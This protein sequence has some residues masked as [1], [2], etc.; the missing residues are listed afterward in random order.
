MKKKKKTK[1]YG[2][3][4]IKFRT[5]LLWANLPKEYKLF[6]SLNT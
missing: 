6:N 5:P 3:E 1:R 4:T 2:Q